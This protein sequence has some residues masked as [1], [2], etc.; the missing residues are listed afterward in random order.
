MG[1]RNDGRRARV[2]LTNLLRNAEMGEG[3][4][5]PNVKGIFPN[6]DLI[7]RL[8]CTVL[9]RQ[10]DEWQVSKRHFSAESLVRETGRLD[11]NPIPYTLLI[12]FVIVG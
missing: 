12:Q 11:T 4:A 8:V 10:N 7:V 2:A 1:S 3:K 6:P 5:T 9:A